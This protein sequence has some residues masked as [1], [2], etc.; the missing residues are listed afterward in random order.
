M[1]RRR[2]PSVPSRST[3]FD[4]P[5]RTTGA[6]FLA[7]AALAAAFPLALVAIER[8]LVVVTL[9]VAASTASALVGKRR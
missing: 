7:F 8:P 6:G 3:G 1:A 4:R 9:L 5:R 2:S